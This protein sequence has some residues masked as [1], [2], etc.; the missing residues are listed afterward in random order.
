M[1]KITTVLLD[2]DGTLA[3]DTIF[4]F[5]SGDVARVFSTYD[6]EGIAMLH[7]HG[8]R[9]VIITS[10]ASPE[11]AARAKWLKTECHS[12]VLNKEWFLKYWAIEQK[13]SLDEI[14]FMGNDLNDLAAIKMCGY[15]A[16]PHNAHMRVWEYC[17]RNG[18]VTEAY[19]GNGAV[20]E[21]VEHLVDRDF[22]VGF[23]HPPYP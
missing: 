12:G 8:I 15:P 3:G 16:A 18:F 14:C 23:V 5:R 13:L 21:L 6:G 10:A 2:C 17:V 1:P 19:G 9:V 22:E 4:Y 11:I 20:R 7:N